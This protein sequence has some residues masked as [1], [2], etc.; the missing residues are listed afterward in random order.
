[1]GNSKRSLHVVLAVAFSVGLIY[2]SF[3]IT[4][5]FVE[6]ITQLSEGYTVTDTFLIYESDTTFSSSKI[7]SGIIFEDPDDII[8]SPVIQCKVTVSQE[9]SLNLWGMDIQ[10]F[11]DIHGTRISGE[12]PTRLYEVLAGAR[13]AEKNSIETGNIIPIIIDNEPVNLVV[14]GTFRSSTQ[15]DDGLI[16]SYDTALVFRPDMQGSF[17]YLEVKTQDAAS[18]LEYYDEPGTSLIPS[19][20]LQDY[21][22]GVS[23]EVRNDLVVVS[24]VI[25]F[26][27]LVT[28]S[29][30]MYKIVSDSMSELVILRSLGVTKNGVITLIVLNSVILSIIGA[31]MGLLLGSIITNAASVSI[32]IILKSIYL[33]VSF[34]ST[35]YLY[36]VLLSIIVGVLGGLASVVFRRPNR[37]IFGAVRTI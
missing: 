20:G 37:E 2:S 21:L 33:P 34:D 10:G 19:L 1:M 11:K 29:H 23:I 24:L 36:C 16:A 12:P 32:F 9:T 30:I 4:D 25:S 7:N 26:L 8:V 18:F 5:S 3:A 22:R 31:L 28:V 6:R 13:L 15:Y 35:L 27:T 14:T 17:S